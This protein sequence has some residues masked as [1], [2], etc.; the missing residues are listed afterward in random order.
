MVFLFSLSL[1]PLLPLPLLPPQVEYSK[2]RYDILDSHQK[3]LKTELET[4]RGKNSQLSNA[5]S[6]HQLRISS[7]TEELFAA[8][9]K[10]VRLE[11]SH[12]TLQNSHSLLEASERQAR[13]QYEQVLKEQRGHRELMTNLQ[14]IQN[15]L[16]RSEFETKTRLGAQIEALE[17][18]LSLSKEKVR[19]E[20][21]RREKMVEAYEIQVNGSGTCSLRS[22][23]SS[24][25]FCE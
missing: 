5:L 21:D 20:E 3:A 23:S 15:N 13:M 24:S 19:S 25:C 6:S 11:V 1:F 22:S 8:K 12:R 7:T 9:D 16:E 4:L 18:D 2:E 14:S 10:L 17:R